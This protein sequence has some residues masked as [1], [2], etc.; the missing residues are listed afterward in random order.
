M[1]VRYAV[2]DLMA[3]KAV[4]G[5]ARRRWS[6]WPRYN[7]ARDVFEDLVSGDNREMSTFLD[8]TYRERRAMQILCLFC[9]TRED[10]HSYLCA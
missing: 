7:E 9:D 2:P 10:R 6:Y 1:P 8:F 3:E 4:P 5:S